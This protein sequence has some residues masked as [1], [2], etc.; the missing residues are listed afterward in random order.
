MKKIGIST[1]KAVG[2]IDQLKQVHKKDLGT[3]DRLLIIT[4]NSIYTVEVIDSDVY[5]VSGG[6]F[7]KRGIS[8]AEL[9]ILGCTWGGS[10]IKLDVVAACGLCVEFGNRVVTSRIRKI[11][12]FKSKSLN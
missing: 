5:K 11:V 4:Q 1:E 6:W 12:I 8:A 9:N 3:G 2:Q 10:M 7:A